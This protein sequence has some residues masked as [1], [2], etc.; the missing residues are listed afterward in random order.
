M[1]RERWNQWIRGASL[2]EWRGRKRYFPN[3]QIAELI[4][5]NGSNSEIKWNIYRKKYQIATRFKSKRTLVLLSFGFSSRSWWRTFWNVFCLR[6][7]G[8]FVTLFGGVNIDVLKIVFGIIWVLNKWVDCLR[9]FRIFVTWFGG[10]SIDVLKIVFGIIWGLNKWVGWG[11]A[12]LNEFSIFPVSL[13][14]SS[15]SLRICTISCHLPI[16]KMPDILASGLEK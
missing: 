16:L 4:R 11:L 5:L 12:L 2:C 14:R 13:N 3:C 1:V 7:F 10:V 15:I 9:I 6:I 8:I